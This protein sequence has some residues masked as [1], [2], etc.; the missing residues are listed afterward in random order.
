MKKTIIGVLLLF[1]IS[2]TVHAQPIDITTT[3]TEANQQRIIDGFFIVYPI[4]DDDDDG[5][6]DYTMKQWLKI[7]IGHFVK[8]TTQEGERRLGHRSVDANTNNDDVT[9]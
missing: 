8:A 3:I 9:E 5:N 1:F 2:T 4:P 7:K 6:P